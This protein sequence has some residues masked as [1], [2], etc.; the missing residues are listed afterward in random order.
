MQHPNCSIIDL[1]YWHA[2]GWYLDYWPASWSIIQYHPPACQ[3]SHTHTLIDVCRDYQRMFHPLSLW[4]INEV[5]T[6][7]PHPWVDVQ[8]ILM[9]TSWHQCVGINSW[10]L[11][12]VQPHVDVQELLRD[13]P[14]LKLLASTCAWTQSLVSGCYPLTDHLASKV[15][16]LH[17]HDVCMRHSIVCKHT[18]GSHVHIMLH[19]HDE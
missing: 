17:Q 7:E 15:N 3:Q 11:E 14:S 2:G 9:S 5:L 16:P 12:H 4:H 10:V 19:S 18:I 8:H 13:V 1:D 6:L